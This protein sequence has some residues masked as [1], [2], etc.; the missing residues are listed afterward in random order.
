M[1]KFGKWIAK[2]RKLIVLL[3][4][5]LL[6]PSLIGISKTRIN[7]DI[8]SYLPNSLETVKGQ[9][10]MVDEFGTGAFSMVVVEDAKVNDVQKIKHKIEK[11]DHVKRFSGTTTW[12]IPL[13]TERMLPKKIRNVFFNKNAT[14]MIALF[15]NTTSSDETMEAVSQMRHVVGKQCFISGMSGIVTDIKTWHWK[16]CQSMWSS[17]R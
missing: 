8:L 16:K 10:I 13:V 15:D 5:L 1:I 14:M 7:Y 11:V 9:D 2:H 12:Q 3:S 6:I 4:V 17:L